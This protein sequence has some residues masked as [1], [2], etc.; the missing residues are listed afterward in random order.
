MPDQSRRSA[1]AQHYRVGVFGASRPDGS[2]LTL[3]ERRTTALL[4]L[5]GAADDARLL[6]VVKDRFDLEPPAQANRAVRNEV[7][8]VLWTGP[9]RWLMV[10]STDQPESLK[11]ELRLAL[12]GTSGKVT[13]LSHARAI[14]RVRGPAARMAL[15]KGCPVDM[16]MHKPGSCVST[17]LGSLS[18][19]I[20]ALDE[21]CL[22][23]YVAR[24]FGLSLWEWLTDSASEF[25]YRVA[26]PIEARKTASPARPHRKPV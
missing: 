20:H 2:G 4:Q 23:V 11:T 7:V 18:V 16:D 3:A 22:D 19:L 1:L 21:T 5:D 15:A 12:D 13:D 8:S 6:A 9:S 10:S 26:A 25:G 24:S 17:L 14:I